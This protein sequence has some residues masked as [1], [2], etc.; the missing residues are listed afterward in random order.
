MNIIDKVFYDNNN[1]IQSYYYIQALK[2][3]NDFEQTKC[4]LLLLST[5]Q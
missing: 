1:V 2:E 4:N 5:E 3:I